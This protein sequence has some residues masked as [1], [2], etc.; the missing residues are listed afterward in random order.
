MLHWF[1]NFRCRE[2]GYA[3]DIFH[4]DVIKWKHF[5]RYR[6]FGRGIHR[7]PVKSLHKGQWRGALMFS[8][9]CTRINGYVNTGEAGDLRR[10][11]ANYDV[12]EWNAISP[13]ECIG[14]SKYAINLPQIDNLVF[15]SLQIDRH[16]WEFNI[17]WYSDK[18][19][20]A[21]MGTHAIDLWKDTVKPMI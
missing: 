20:R 10:H 11:R 21:N 3:L 9:I 12:I 17:Y 7:S 19:I 2:I 6:L 4:D 13:V 15:L 5:P 8:L 16:R 14:Y 1:T 18:Q